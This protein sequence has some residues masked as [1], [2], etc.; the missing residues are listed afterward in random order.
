M[1]LPVTFLGTWL[2]LQTG[3]WTLHVIRII[4]TQSVLFALF[5]V[6]GNIII[7]ERAIRATLG[8]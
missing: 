5:C 4:Y 3:K 1:I 6:F 2:F 8:F 7:I